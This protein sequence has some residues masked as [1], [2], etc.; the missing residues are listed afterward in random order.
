LFQTLRP[1]T[2]PPLSR[3]DRDIYG[4]GW[5]TPLIGEEKKRKERIRMKGKSKESIRR[6]G[7]SKESIRRKGEGKERIRKEKK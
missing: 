2:P 5:G 3:W 7:K 1:P 4:G 6:K